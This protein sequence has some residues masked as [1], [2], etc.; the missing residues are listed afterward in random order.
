MCV[1]IPGNASTVGISG[2]VFTLPEVVIQL[3]DAT[4]AGFAVFTLIRLEAALISVRLLFIRRHRSIGLADLM[5]DFHCR[6]F[7]HGISHMGVN[8]QRGRRGNMTNDSRQRFHIH[9]VL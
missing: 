4:G 3:V 6:L 9:P 5:V 8:V 1:D 2:G 7:L